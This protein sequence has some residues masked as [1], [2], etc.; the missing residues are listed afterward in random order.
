MDK[1]NSY[2]ITNPVFNTA[3][4]T[5]Y[6]LAES[7]NE[8]AKKLVERTGFDKELAYGANPAFEVMVLPNTIGQDVRYEAVNRLVRLSGN[9]NILDLA[10]GFS[11]RGLEM[12][13][14]GYNYHGGDLQ[15]VVPVIE[16][17][18]KE[19]AGDDAEKINYYVV[20]VT[21][22]ESCLKAVETFDGPVTIIT[23]GLML[24]L[25]DVEKKTVFENIATLLKKKGGVYI[26][27]DF[28]SNVLAL[29]MCQAIMDV[30]ALTAVQKTQE[31]FSQKG[32]CDTD[33]QM[34]SPGELASR[35]LDTV[36]IK[37][38]MQTLYPVTA[39]AK[40]YRIIKDADKLSELK[41]VL[42]D[43]IILYAQ[44][45]STKDT[46][47]SKDEKNDDAFSSSCNMN[48]DKLC[49]TVCG[50]MDSLTAPSI[51]EE[52]RKVSEKQNI[53]SIE[54]DFS[55]L[56]YISSAGLRVLLGIKKDLNKDVN[57]IGANDDIREVFRMTGFDQVL[58]VLD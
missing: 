27:P 29:R 28:N 16:P 1:T 52:Y 15:M 12:V 33:A 54:F 45:D 7:G 36:P 8:Y 38:E 17:I 51:V 41:K 20:D 47:K 37:Y 46:D 9:K 43:G 24:Y 40:S 22:L 13:K 32:D 11:P 56:S 31:Q 42:A 23:E 39:D 57:I 5:S 55:N 14:E 53:N 34:L 26:C 6:F 44:Y 35:I 58:N 2:E 30:D 19:L 25:N 21:D 50:R 49:F 18:I 3:K 48:G 4:M 10:C